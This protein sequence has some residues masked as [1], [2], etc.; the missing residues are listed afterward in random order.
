MN[1][2]GYSYWGAFNR[3]RRMEKQ[4]LVEKMGSINPGAYCLTN[5]GIRRLDYYGRRKATA[6]D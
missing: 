5:E 3:L 6:I 2:F 4:N 1:E